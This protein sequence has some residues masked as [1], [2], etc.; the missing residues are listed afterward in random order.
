MVAELND[1]AALDDRNFVGIPNGGEPVGNDEYGFSVHQT[2]QTLFDLLLGS[3][4][5]G[6]GCL[7]HN[8]HRRLCHRSARNVQKLPLGNQTIFDCHI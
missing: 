2:I 7:I 8:Q 6:G 3:G 1:F 4:I 5:D